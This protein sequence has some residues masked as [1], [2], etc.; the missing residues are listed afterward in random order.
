M[1]NQ[2]QL[3][4]Y[5]EYRDGHLWWIKKSGNQS[6]IGERVGCQESSGY[7]KCSLFGKRYRE[8]QLVFLYFHGYIPRY[9]DH[10]NGIRY[11][12]RIEN[13]RYA[14]NQQNSCNRNGVNGTSSTYKGVTWN[15][16]VGKW[17]ASIHYN[18]KNIY[19]GLFDC[20][21]EAANAY[22]K[23]AAKIHKEYAKVNF[24]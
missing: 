18:Y 5:L 8:H 22:D 10:I 3:K 19:I 2:K 11:D 16:A 20:E 14:T 13:L 9:V 17:Q 24:G 6:K 1:I 7:I 4:E 12:N 21:I 15:K 23:E